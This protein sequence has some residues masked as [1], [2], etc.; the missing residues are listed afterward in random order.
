M[1]AKDE[2][3]H[4]ISTTS[5]STSSLRT[6]SPTWVLTSRSQPAL[7]QHALERLSTGF[8]KQAGIHPEA[9]AHGRRS[10][11]KDVKIVVDVLK[12]AK[13]LDV[14]ERRAHGMFP[15]FTPDPVHK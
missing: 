3:S 10:D 4:A 13:V 12:K 14:T 1:V 15:K 6:S 5:T 9:S 2:T 8:D 11:E 7:G